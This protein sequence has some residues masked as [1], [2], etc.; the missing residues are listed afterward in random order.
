MKLWWLPLVLLLLALPL[1]PA[2]LEWHYTPENGLT[3][4]VRY[5]FLS[6][7]IGGQSAVLS[8]KKEKKEPVKEKE[9][10]GAK[11]KLL[12]TVKL[13]AGQVRGW[14]LRLKRLLQHVHVHRFALQIKV[15]EAD[16][17][18]T[19][20]EYGTVCGVVYPLLS[21]INGV[22]RLPMDEVCIWCDYETQKADLKCFG[23]ASIRPIW[24]LMFLV[25]TVGGILSQKNHRKGDKVQ[26]G[27]QT[28]S[29]DS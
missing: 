24:I 19:A 4:R 7:R 17:A 3:G 23:K 18:V 29:T 14:L 1:I 5:L 9:E 13:L 11:Q 10:R 21:A 20:L 27:Q 22:V 6:Y 25:A 15:S 26:H 8:K 12:E 28:Q 16:A 2:S